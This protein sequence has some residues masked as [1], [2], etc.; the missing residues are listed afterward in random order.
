[1]LA[2]P[3]DMMALTIAE[4]V[5]D[6]LSNHIA[7]GRGA[8]AA[9]GANRMPALSSAV[10]SYIESVTILVDANDAGRRGSNELARRLH[11]RGVEILMLS[12]GGV[13]EP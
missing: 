8:W 3:S 4:G 2:P 6:A 12:S 9:G 13:D 5:E 11:A 1:V 7:S 10:P